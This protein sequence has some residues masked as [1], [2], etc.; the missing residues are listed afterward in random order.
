MLSFY[1]LYFRFF[2]FASPQKNSPE[3]FDLRN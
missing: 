3:I 2:A 1:I